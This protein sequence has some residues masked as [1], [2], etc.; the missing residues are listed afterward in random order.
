VSTAVSGRSRPLVLPPELDP[1]LTQAERLLATED[2]RYGG[3]VAVLAALP[4]ELAATD[5]LNEALARTG[6]VP[7]LRRDGERWQLVVV[8]ERPTA[9]EVAAAA[10]GLA[11]LV[12]ATGWTRVK[13]CTVPGCGRPFVDRTNGCSRHRCG[14]HIRRE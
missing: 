3:L 7:R 11:A 12:A 4:D 8:G 6:A 1:A 5:R 10:G 2:A 14:E 9:G 13:R